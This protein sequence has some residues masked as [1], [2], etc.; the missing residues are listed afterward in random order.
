MSNSVFSGGMMTDERIK[1]S[2]EELLDLQNASSSSGLPI[3]L[4]T[5]L[6]KMD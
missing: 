3:N 6:L 4:N 2:I 5:D 1:Y